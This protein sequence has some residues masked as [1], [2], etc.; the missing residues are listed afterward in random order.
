MIYSLFFSYVF[1]SSSASANVFEGMECASSAAIAADPIV[2][3]QMNSKEIE[4]LK[5]RMEDLKNIKSRVDNIDEGTK[6]NTQGIKKLAD[7]VKNA[8]S[9]ALGGYDGDDKKIP[10]VTGL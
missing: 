1:E 2:L 9:D 6:Q 3:S 5:K 8:G 4:E 10:K 7:E